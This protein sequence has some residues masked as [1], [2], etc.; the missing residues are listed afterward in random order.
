M[1]KEQT[2]FNGKRKRGRRPDP[3]NVLRRELNIE[4]RKVNKQL[5]RLAKHGYKNQWA[6]KTLFNRLDVVSGLTTKGR[7]KLKLIKPGRELSVGDIR[8]I[9]TSI[10]DFRKSESSKI[11]GIKRIEARIKDTIKERVTTI[12]IESGLSINEPTKKEIQ[13]L[14]NLWENRNFNRLLEYID[15]ST[16]FV[17]LTRA[18]E[19]NKMPDD[20]VNEVSK[21]VLDIEDDDIKDAL[22]HVYKDYLKMFND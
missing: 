20:F 18:K 11:K 4:I 6:Y 2:R 5:A 10:K 3:K 15:P 9:R 1:A 17:L 19:I 12:D 16:L 8:E 14:Y 22:K 13:S 21:Y 7:T